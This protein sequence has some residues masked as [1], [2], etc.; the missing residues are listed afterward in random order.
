MYCISSLCSQSKNLDM[1]HENYMRH[2]KINIL[3]LTLMCLQHVCV[4]ALYI[5]LNRNSVLQSSVM[6]ARSWYCTVYM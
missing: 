4:E 5:H 2:E 1:R 6:H 3:G